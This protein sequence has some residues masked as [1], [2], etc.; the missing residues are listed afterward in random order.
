MEVLNCATLKQ[1]YNL[2]NCHGLKDYPTH[3]IINGK[4]FLENI[5][6]V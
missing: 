3:P 1:K 4:L 2:Y 5:L 6:P